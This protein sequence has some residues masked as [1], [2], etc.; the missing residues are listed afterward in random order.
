M[1]TIGL[2]QAARIFQ[3]STAGRRE[4]SRLDQHLADD[5]GVAT[6]VEENRAAYTRAEGLRVLELMR[7]NGWRQGHVPEIVRFALLDMRDEGLSQPEIAALLSLT[8]DQ[9]RVMAN[10]LRRP[11]SPVPL[12]G[13]V[14]QG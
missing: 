10:G 9:V 6:A 11:R 1:R 12:L 5:V 13:L 2:V 7:E 3:W 14:A 8:L 4:Y